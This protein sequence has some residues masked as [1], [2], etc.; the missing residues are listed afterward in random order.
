MTT[1]F[2]NVSTKNPYRKGTNLQD[3]FHF[4]S[5]GHAH[6]LAFITSYV[7]GQTP[8]EYHNRVLRRQTAS[9][10]RTIRLQNNGV[11]ITYN[12]LT[13]MYLMRDCGHVV[14]RGLP[15]WMDPWGLD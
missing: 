9:A 2:I 8:S 4:M 6:S 3:I 10:L 14:L 5:D 13:K 15:H 1:D 7:R 11:S 12:R